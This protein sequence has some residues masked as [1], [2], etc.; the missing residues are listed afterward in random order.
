MRPLLVFIGPSGVGKST[1]VR[2]LI[3]SNHIRLLPTWTTRPQRYDEDGGESEHHFVSDPDFDDAIRS[4]E[5]IDAVSLFGLPYRYG[6]PRLETTLVG[7]VATLMGRAHL[8]DRLRTHT[9]NM[10]VYQIEADPQVVRRRLQEREH[11][12]AELGDRWKLF[13]RELELG[14][15]AADRRFINDGPTGNLY[16]N[17]R[18]A[19][20]DDYS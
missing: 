5:V 10:R 2:K 19:I 18:Q 17:V 4:G 1:L 20:E 3:A 8:L 9:Q 7:P 14:R 13:D 15:A 16:N 11:E 12:G 6:L